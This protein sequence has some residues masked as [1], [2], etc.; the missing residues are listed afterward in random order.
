MDGWMK[1]RLETQSRSDGKQRSE[2]DRVKSCCVAELN[3][4]LSA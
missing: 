1:E 2:Q 4:G 3:P